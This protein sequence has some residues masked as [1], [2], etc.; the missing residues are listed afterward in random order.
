MDNE[1]TAVADVMADTAD[2]ASPEE[3][4]QLPVTDE[5][6]VSSG[7]PVEPE[8]QAEGEA[9]QAQ[10][11]DE[12]PPLAPWE[13]AHEQYKET[14]EFTEFV[15]D[16][17]DDATRQG[18]RREAGKRRDTQAQIQQTNVAIGQLNSHLQE[19]LDAPD[20][21]DATTLG[22]VFANNPNLD[23]VVRHISN[24]MVNDTSEARAGGAAA[25][26][27]ALGAH[28]YGDP[29][30]ANK[31]ALEVQ[32]DFQEQIY[33]L[34]SNED[35]GK[36]FYEEVA[37]RYDR[38]LKPMFKKAQQPLLDEIATLKSEIATFK[39][40]RPG[41]DTTDKVPSVSKAYNTLADAQRDHAAGKINNDRMR[42]IRTEFLAVKE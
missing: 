19:L 2:T 24:G 35:A 26:F 20:K 28:K 41:P 21:L 14:P 1:R 27:A 25:M 23:A 18:Q 37:Q 16:I 8:P 31:V 6:D 3:P 7:Q 38:L 22:Q 4:S 17:T 13:E 39:T 32:E 9:E 30:A 42:E 10:Q 12:P 34:A 15:K 36:A 5:T 29:A 11:Q 40:Q 33:S